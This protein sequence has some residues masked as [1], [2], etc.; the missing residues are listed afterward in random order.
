MVLQ[1]DINTHTAFLNVFIFTFIDV[2]FNYRFILIRCVAIIN[3]KV[4]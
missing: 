1:F 4:S 3:F 2:L